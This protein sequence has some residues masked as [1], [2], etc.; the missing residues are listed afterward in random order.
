MNSKYEKVT[1]E[2][3]GILGDD[4]YNPKIYEPVDEE[5]DIKSLH[6]LIDKCVT[7]KYERL[8]KNVRF[9]NKGDKVLISYN[10]NPG[11]KPIAGNTMYITECI[12]GDKPYEDCYKVSKEMDDGIFWVVCHADIEGMWTTDYWMPLSEPF[13]SGGTSNGGDRDGDNV[14]CPVM[15]NM[16]R[17]NDLTVSADQISPGRLIKNT[18]C[19]HKIELKSFKREYVTYCTKCGKIFSSRKK[20][21]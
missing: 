17:P 20:R 19:T 2:E 18:D 21:K 9:Y 12:Y 3:L 4:V 15:D 11:V 1:L 10:C 16:L 6:D 14:N 13:G 7:E 5:A 8:N